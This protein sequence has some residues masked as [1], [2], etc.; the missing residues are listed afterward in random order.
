MAHEALLDRTPILYDNIYRV[1]GALPLQQAVTA[2]QAE[3]ETVMGVDGRFD[4]ILLGMGTDGHTASLF[5]GTTALEERER[6]VVAV[7]VERLNA[8][9]VTLTLPVINAACHVMFLLQRLVFP[10]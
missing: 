3:L 1:Q 10:S 7:Y 2:Y 5:P 6:P 8:W 9:R 4:L